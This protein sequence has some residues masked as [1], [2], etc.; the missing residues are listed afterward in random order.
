M[1]DS[2]MDLVGEFERAPEKKAV[3]SPARLRTLADHMDKQIEAKLNPAVSNQNL[4]RRRADIAERMHEDGK[5]LQ[6]VQAKLR[7][8]ADRIE[9]DDL[10]ESLIGIKSRK[11]VEFLRDAVRNNNVWLEHGAG[12][13]EYDREWIKAQRQTLEHMGIKNRATFEQAKKDIV[14]I[15]KA[16]VS[17]DE[18]QSHNVKALERELI[19]SKIPGFFPTPK[20]TIK[21]ML[22]RADLQ[23]GQKV[24]EPSA[25]KGDL[26]EAIREILGE[27]PEVAEISRTLRNILEARG[28]DPIEFDFLEMKKGGSGYDRIIQN[29][30]FEHGQDI[31]HIRHAYDLLKPGGKV[32]SLMSEGPFFHNDKA[33]K[34]FREWLDEVEGRSEK[35]PPKAFTGKESFRQSGSS[36]RLVEIIKKKLD[37]EKGGRP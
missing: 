29:P 25:G 1:S 3:A 14:N 28:Y 11:D 26:A 19:G 32:V 23:P 22:E 35:L 5:W 37:E 31:E 4:T 27:R 36:I 18:T 24:L 33:S 12:Q 17:E 20:P 16:Q 6:D 7:E 2:E 13:T 10:P 8:I 21:A 9:A 30:P 15:C 34:S